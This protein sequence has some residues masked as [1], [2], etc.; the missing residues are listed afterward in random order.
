MVHLSSVELREKEGAAAAAVPS[1]GLVLDQF[2]I[3]EAESCRRQQVPKSCRRQLA[4]K[5][6][7]AAS[8][9]LPKAASQN[10]AA[11]SEPRAK[12]AAEGSKPGAKEVLRQAAS[13]KR[14]KLQC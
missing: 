8:K 2:G 6:R 10:A 13:K 4:R 9:E 3:E 7:Q 11:S 14:R 12:E 5:L 1:A